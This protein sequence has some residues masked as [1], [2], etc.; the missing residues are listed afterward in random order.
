M[1]T[2]RTVWN[3]TKEVMVISPVFRDSLLKEL[4]ATAEEFEVEGEIRS[5]LLPALLIGALDA[6]SWDK[7]E[8]NAVAMRL[9]RDTLRQS[10]V[11]ET[12]KAAYASLVGLTQRKGVMQFPSEEIVMARTKLPDDAR[13]FMASL[14]FSES[15]QDAIAT[16]LGY[17][18]IPKVGV[19]AFKPGICI[20]SEIVGADT[21]VRVLAHETTHALSNLLGLVAPV[22][23][24]EEVVAETSAFIVARTCG[25]TQ[26]GFSETY[27]AANFLMLAGAGV[28]AEV[29][30]AGMALGANLAQDILAE[31]TK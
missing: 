31:I 24:L 10:Q 13:Q 5:R 6:A 8:L 4:D 17:F 14:G 28:P 16:P 20:R 1:Y 15:D 12:S 7:N 2:I 18:A 3:C 27:L 26:P 19:N 29:A 30:M 9:Q 22:T 21:G 23:E 11:T 25:F